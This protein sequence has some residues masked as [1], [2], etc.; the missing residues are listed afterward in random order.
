MMAGSKQHAELKSI[1]NELSLSEK[2][3]AKDIIKTREQIEKYSR[4]KMTIKMT[5]LKL[6][7]LFMHKQE[8]VKWDITS[9]PCPVCEK[10]LESSKFTAEFQ[11]TDKSY[12]VEELNSIQKRKKHTITNR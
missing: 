12:L 9:N 2:R 3:V 4:L 11:H 8:S 6:I 1:F 10:P 7:V 5:L